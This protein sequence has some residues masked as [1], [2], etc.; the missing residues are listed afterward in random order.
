MWAHYYYYYYD[1]DYYYCYYYE[2]P[3]LGACGLGHVTITNSSNCADVEAGTPR[4]CRTR[5]FQVTD[6]QPLT[7]LICF[8]LPPSLFLSLLWLLRVVVAVFVLLEVVVVLLLLLLLLLPVPVP[9]PVLVLAL[10]LLLPLQVLL[11]GAS[12]AA[13]SKWFC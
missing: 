10:L 7:S 6:P 8:C 11:L 1:D 4:D 9:V 12:A 2:L 13:S 5:S 3:L